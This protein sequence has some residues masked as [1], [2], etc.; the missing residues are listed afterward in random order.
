[1]NS[2]FYSFDHKGV[3]FIVLDGNDIPVGHQSGYPCYIA[4]DQISWL[5]ENLKQTNAFSI[6]FVHQSIER[7]MDGSIK[8]GSEVRNLLEK[9]NHQAGFRKV[10]ACFSGH[11]RRDYV[12]W[13]NNILYSQINSASYYWIGEDFLEVRYDSN[14]HI[15]NILIYILTNFLLFLCPLLKKRMA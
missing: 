5:Y 11:H 4:A 12:R 9:V 7:E 10:I 6:V 14:L 1:M 15:L 3:H 8:N 2:R 13:I